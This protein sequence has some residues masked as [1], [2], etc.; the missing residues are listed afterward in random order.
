[1]MSIKQVKWQLMN[2][3]ESELTDL[4]EVDI[5][6]SGKLIRHGLKGNLVN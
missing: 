3:I 1:M 5:P 2:N 6:F 4:T